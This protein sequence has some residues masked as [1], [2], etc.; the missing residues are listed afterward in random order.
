MDNREAVSPAEGEN[1]RVL[2]LRFDSEPF[3]AFGLSRF[4]GDRS[5]GGGSPPPDREAD[6]ETGPPL[7]EEVPLQTVSG[8][9]AASEPPHQDS[10]TPP[11]QSVNTRLILKWVETGA[12]F[13]VLV[14]LVF[15]YEHIR[16][17]V[18]FLWLTA[19]LHQ[20]NDIMKRQVALKS[21]CKIPVLLFLVWFLAVQA[22]CVYF[23]FSNEKLWRHLIFLDTDGKPKD[24]W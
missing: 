18:V 22:H 19:V 4:F 10:S 8:P 14:L 1:A 16:G 15:V 13:L 6:L 3:R 5:G 7:L 2:T 9:S 17:I 24:V 12:P 21:E 20:A 23:W 11:E